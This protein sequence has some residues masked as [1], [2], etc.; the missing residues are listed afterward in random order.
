MRL[1]GSL[2]FVLAACGDD[3]SGGGGIFDAAVDTNG[4]ADADLPSCA[5][6]GFCSD[7]PMCGVGCCAFGE[8]CVNDECRCGNDPACMSGDFCTSGGP[9]APAAGG[10]GLF[11]CG[12]A[13]GVGCPI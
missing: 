10:C 1:L 6:N 13:S 7:G 9:V 4:S 5:A 11:C 2:V 12:P 8:H 3:D